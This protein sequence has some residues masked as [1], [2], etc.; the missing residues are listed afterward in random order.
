MQTCKD[1]HEATQ[2]RHVWT[3]QLEKLRQQDPM[4]RSATPP[5]ASL[6][7]QE[8]KTFVTRRTRLRLRW[9]KDAK[10]DDFAA[11]GLV[12]FH[13]VEDLRLLPGGKSMLVISNFEGATLCRIEMHEDRVSLP[14]VAKLPRNRSAPQQW[15][16]LTAMSPCPILAQREEDV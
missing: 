15:Q 1:L 3:D 16:L 14:V 12:E 8:L 7:A 6:S 13:G 5:L 9:D 4:L 10:E 11:M 2:D